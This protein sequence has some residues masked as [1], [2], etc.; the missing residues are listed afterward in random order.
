MNKE[1][2]CPHCE[3]ITPFR[4]ITKRETLPVMGEAVE[5]QARVRRCAVCGGEYAPTELEE[6]NFKTAYDIYRQRHNLLNPQQIKAIREKYG[7]SQR[8][9][10][11]LLGWGD[12]TVHRY[13]AG[14]LPDTAYNIMLVLIDEPLNALKVFMLNR[15]NLAPGVAEK[16]KT[17]I[18]EL[19]RKS[20]RNTGYGSG[21]AG[22]VV[23][24]LSSVCVKEPE[25]GRFVGTATRLPG[26]S[27]GKA[28]T[29]G[30]VKKRKP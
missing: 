19:I 22:E 16:L 28:A 30:T 2:F 29:G 8:N 17:R 4:L 1:D 12:I 13:E 27:N 9:F 26:N 6:E 15:N 3:E 5:Y 25:H 20:G 14:A 18:Q 23:D 7:L 10:S 24:S 21:E 11:R